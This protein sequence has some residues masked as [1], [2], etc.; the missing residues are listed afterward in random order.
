MLSYEERV[1][2]LYREFESK[3]VSMTPKSRGLFERARKVLPGGVTYAIR[4]F[5][6]YPIYVS[7]A[8]GVHVWDVDGNVYV[9]FWM[10]HG[11]NV[12]GHAPRFVIEAVRDAS[13]NGT[14]LGFESLPPVE[15]AEFLSKVVPGLESLRFTNS[16]TEANMYAARLARAYSGR[17][18][19]VKVE[20]GWHG[21]YDSLH[22]GVTP[23]FVGPESAGLPEEFVKYT[24]PVPFNDLEALEEALRRYPV[25]AVF[26]E[27]VL[28]AGGCIAPVEGYLRG[29]RELVDRYGSLLV[30]DEV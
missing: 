29:V 22:T 10:G 17:K 11:A 4:F 6:P 15:Y 7:R 13:L 30:F 20:G 21:G 27:P 23:P 1:E 28:G 18:Y 19:V 16:G 12:L 2:L 25:A 8:E 14:H 24:I 3:Y 5:K 9:D 26:I